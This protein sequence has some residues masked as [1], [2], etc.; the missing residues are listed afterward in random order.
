MIVIVYTIYKVVET[1][2]NCILEY[3][4]YVLSKQIQKQLP[5]CLSQRLKNILLVVNHTLQ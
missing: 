4:I 5:V 1:H 3:K 2:T